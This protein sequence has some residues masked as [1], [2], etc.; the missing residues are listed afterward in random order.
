ME[1]LTTD[2]DD[3]YSIEIDSVEIAKLKRQKR[4]INVTHPDIDEF[5][6]FK[7]VKLTGSCCWKVRDQYKKGKDADY[8][9]PGTHE[10]GWPIKSV[11]LLKNCNMAISVPKTDSQQ[12]EENGNSETIMCSSKMCEIVEQNNE[13]SNTTRGQ[14]ISATTLTAEKPSI[15]SEFGET[16]EN[17]TEDQDNTK[18]IISDSKPIQQKHSTANDPEHQI[19][20]SETLSNSSDIKPQWFFYL[21]FCHF[22]FYLIIGNKC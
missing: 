6:K 21:F 2:Y 20:V 3:E 8:A 7:L 17:N 4:S 10:P 18:E 11:K 1:L 22:L 9:I 5:L 14:P 15:E 12:P 19:R 13:V 16:E